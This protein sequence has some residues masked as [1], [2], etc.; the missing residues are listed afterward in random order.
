MKH[1]II[2]CADCHTTLVRC[3]CPETHAVETRPGPC[4][5]CLG[6]PRKTKA[7]E[8]KELNDR[9]KELEAKVPRWQP[10][11]TAPKDGRLLLIWDDTVPGPEIGW[12]EL[13]NPHAMKHGFSTMRPRF[14]MPLPDPPEVT[15]ETP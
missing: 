11:E 12:Y 4:K 9:I 15:D 3:R 14:W 6:R 1:G 13:D 10:I 2:K 8:I 7:A 5:S